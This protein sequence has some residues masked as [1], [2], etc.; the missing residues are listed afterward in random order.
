MALPVSE[1][2][3]ACILKVLSPGQ[4]GSCN[5]QKGSSVTSSPCQS[6]MAIF[7]RTP[8]ESLAV[9]NF[10]NLLCNAW[11]GP[12]SPVSNYASE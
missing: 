11:Q 6:P 10:T 4:K 9:S 7:A 8:L 3:Q 5:I 2:A 12:V 1:Q